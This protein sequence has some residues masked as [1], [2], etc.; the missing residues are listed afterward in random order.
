L[1]FN[2]A[3]KDPVMIHVIRL[4]N[5]T[6]SKNL[7]VNYAKQLDLDIERNILICRMKSNEVFII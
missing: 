5:Q 3:K 4:I 2:I 7:N 1:I 6:P